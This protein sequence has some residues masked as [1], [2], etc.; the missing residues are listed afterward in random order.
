MDP[1][2]TGNTNITRTAYVIEKSFREFVEESFP[3]ILLKK[4]VD[5]SLQ[6]GVKN[7]YSA[8]S[9]YPFRPKQYFFMRIFVHRLVSFDVTQ[10]P[11]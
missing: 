4:I 2:P 10:K 9:L 6:L 11:L 8:T 3:V 1:S 5:L 7:I